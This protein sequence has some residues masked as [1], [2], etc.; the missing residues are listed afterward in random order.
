MTPNY[1]K[2]YK[3]TLETYTLIAHFYRNVTKKSKGSFID[4]HLLIRLQTKK[5]EGNVKKHLLAPQWFTQ[6]L[7]SA[8]VWACKNEPG[9]PQEILTGKGKE[10]KEREEEEEEEE[11]S[12]GLCLSRV[13]D[14]EIN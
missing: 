8:N 9:N 12:C 13:Y 3:F 7:N 14:P 4:C 1:I 10:R 11:D 2:V 5:E 6:C